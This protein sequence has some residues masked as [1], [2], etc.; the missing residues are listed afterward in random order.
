MQH[1]FL[2]HQIQGCLSEHIKENGKRNYRGKPVFRGKK[3][4]NRVKLRKR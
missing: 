1:D 2:P 3:S 4:S